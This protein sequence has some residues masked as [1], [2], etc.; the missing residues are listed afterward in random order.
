MIQTTITY[1]EARAALRSR[2][3]ISVDKTECPNCGGNTTD[4]EIGGFNG[5]R[6][7]MSCEDCGERETIRFNPE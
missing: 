1:E 4:W 7:Y 5:S 3:A 2:W 6:L